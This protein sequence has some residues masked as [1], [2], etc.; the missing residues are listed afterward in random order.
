MSQVKKLSVL[1]VLCMLVLVQSTAFNSPLLIL[2][3]SPLNKMLYI[4]Q[5]LYSLT[6]GACLFNIGV[7]VNFFLTVDKTPILRI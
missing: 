3:L 2:S 4:L 6:M 7:Q 1:M 5:M